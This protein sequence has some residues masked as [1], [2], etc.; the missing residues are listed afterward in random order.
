MEDPDD[1]GADRTRELDGLL[2]DGDGAR[3]EGVDLGEGRDCTEG[4]EL[5]RDEDRTDGRETA[6]WEV[7]LDLETEGLDWLRGVRLVTDPR[8]PDE[9][10]EMLRLE[11][12]GRDD[13]GLRFGVRLTLGPDRPLDRELGR[14]R[15]NVP[16]DPVRLGRVTNDG[17]WDE[18]RPREP[19]ETFP[20]AAT[21]G[22]DNCRLLRLVKDPLD[23]DEGRERL[24]LGA[25]ERDDCGARVGVRTTFTPDRPLDRES[26][27]CRTS[28][29][30]DPVRSER[31]TADRRDGTRTTEP[32][33]PLLATPARREPVPTIRSRVRS[34]GPEADLEERTPLLELTAF[35]PR[36]RGRR[37][38][39]GRPSRK[40]P[41]MVLEAT[42]RVLAGPLPRSR[43]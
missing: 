26:G 29:R 13:C 36:P 14:W 19:L 43:P 42:T 34:R 28:D 9:D 4:R 12:E 21:G 25:V 6:R 10:R 17:C 3:K 27:R 18:V 11:D 23:P 8:D 1:L 16:V 7:D 24:R 41:T 31:L 38:S 37:S 39:L 35:G 40:L 32:S 30:V 20:G 22:I 33:E 15:V 2:L 5:E